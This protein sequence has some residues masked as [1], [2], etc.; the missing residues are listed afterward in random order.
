MSPA[1][2]AAFWRAISASLVTAMRSECISCMRASSA[3]TGLNVPAPTCRVRRTW[4]RQTHRGKHMYLSEN[5]DVGKMQWLKVMDTHLPYAAPHARIHTVGKAESHA[6]AADARS[7][8]RVTVGVEPCVRSRTNVYAY[9]SRQPRYLSRQPRYLS[10]RQT[11]LF[12]ALGHHLI[13]DVLAE[14][15]AS[16]RPPRSETVCVCVCVVYVACLRAGVGAC[17]RA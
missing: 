17:V 1:P 16:L 6:D 8:K 12:Y 2:D 9:A 11:H 3:V 7:R 4:R 14:V 13:H 15:Q 5:V 10:G